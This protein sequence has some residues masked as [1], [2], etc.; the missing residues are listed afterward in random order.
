MLRSGMEKFMQYDYAGAPWNHHGKAGNG[1]FSLR[2]VDVMME[3]CLKVC[4]RHNENEPEDLV[5]SD[6]VERR[7][8][9][10]I[11][12]DVAYSFSLESNC[13]TLNHLS[14][15][16]GILD[17][18]MAIHKPWNSISSYKLGRIFRYSLD[19]LKQSDNIV[20]LMKNDSLQTVNIASENTSMS[21]DFFK[22][23]NKH[24][25]DK[26]YHHAYHRFYPQYI[27]RF[28]EL[29][30]D[31]GMIEIGIAE[32]SSL[33]AW[34]D[35]FKR[36]FIYG[37]DIGLSMRGERYEIYPIDQS[38]IELLKNFKTKVNHNIFFIID[39]GSHLPEHQIMTFD[40]FFRDL[41][42]PGGVY[43]VEDIETSY[44]KRNNV[45]GY[46][47]RY[48]INHKNSAVE[49]FKKVI[50]YI[51]NEFL[52][53]SDYQNLIREFGSKVSAETLNLIQSIS[54]GQ[55]CVI[56]TKKSNEE[57]LNYPKRSYRFAQNI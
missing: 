56:L 15:E 20:Q 14:L 21:G 8:Y 49:F 7:R 6:F 18:H 55:N 34:L 52:S 16:G 17:A 4:G 39:D 5:F 45:Y 40:V 28:R 53:E 50:D 43:I 57:I 44:W 29:S 12:F 36:P 25:T 19:L 42:L 41:L 33:R 35:Y 26:I 2:S 27:E 13:V 51:N 48:G 46:E 38:K 24:R 54:F 9:K 10:L 23:G 30:E 11:P 47:T 31:Y 22:F 37:I 1:G 32:S 3:A